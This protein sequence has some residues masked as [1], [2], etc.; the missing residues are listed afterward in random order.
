MKRAVLGML[1]PALLGVAACGGDERAPRRVDATPAMVGAT[2][3]SLVGLWDD[4]HDGE[5][6]KLDLRADGSAHI[7]SLAVV[8]ASWTLDPASSRVTITSRR[9]ADGSTV[10]EVF[11]YKPADGVLAGRSSG[12]SGP[13]HVF[14]RA[15]P[16]AVAWWS[17]VRPGAEADE[18][19][20]E[21]R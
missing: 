17:R 13:E 21:G 15:S 7:V 11:T 12:P 9:P 18:A 14:R 16:H 1:L 2:E 3:A 20:R 19:Q 8:P 10:T 5:N 6:M 4:G